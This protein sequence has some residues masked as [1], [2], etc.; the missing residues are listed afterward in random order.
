MPK[1]EIARRIAAVR[2]NEVAKNYRDSAQQF[3]KQYT[4]P[5]EALEESAP[6]PQPGKMVTAVAAR[7]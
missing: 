5:A 1:A 3:I 4:T 6:P 2:A 7:P